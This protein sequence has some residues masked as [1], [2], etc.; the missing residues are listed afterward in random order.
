MLTGLMPA[1]TRKSTN[2]DFILVWPD[3][4]SSPPTNT[5][6]RVARSITPGS[7]VFCGLPLMK[8]EPSRMEATANITDGAISAWSLSMAAK[9]LSAVSCTPAVTSQKRSVL[10]LHSTI[11]LSKPFAALNSRMLRRSSSTCSDLEPER[12]LLARS[13]WLAAM[14]SG[15]YT[16]GNGTRSFMCEYSL[17]CRSTW[18]TS[19]R[20]MASPRFMLLMSQPPITR[21]LGFTMGRIEENGTYTSA[22]P[23]VPTLIV[24]A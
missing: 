24:D 12:T 16:E 2:T 8:E 22:T 18:N 21:S 10:A 11:T 4:K 1:D 13:A 5:P 14:K 23:C 17:R 20:V 19:A 3:L 15:T 9:M 6:L 7:T